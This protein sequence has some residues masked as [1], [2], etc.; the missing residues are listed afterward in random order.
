MGYSAIQIDGGLTISDNTTGAMREGVARHRGINGHVKELR[1]VRELS[2]ED[3]LREFQDA[4][5]D[6]GFEA[7][8][9]NHDGKDQISLCWQGDKIGSW[10]EG[11][12]DSLAPFFDPGSRIVFSGEDGC[13]WQEG[14]KDGKR[15][16]DSPSMIPEDQ[17]QQ[18]QRNLDALERQIN[19]LSLDTRSLLAVVK[20]NAL[21]TDIAT[22]QAED[23]Q[24]IQALVNG[25]KAALKE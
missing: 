20:D 13:V 22:Q 9:F 16:Q 23:L 6:C 11:F 2:D 17:I 8:F 1:E 19:R 14:F 5:E 24:E 10:M 3:L 4:A 12:L 7:D 21:A 18:A 15:V 25:I